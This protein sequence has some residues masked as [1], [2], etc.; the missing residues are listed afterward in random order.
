MIFC[1]C[2]CGQTRLKYDLQG[3]ERLYIKYH[4]NNCRQYSKEKKRKLRYDKGITYEQKFGKEKAE[5][6][7]ERIKI[8][9]KNNSS[10]KHFKKG[11][12]GYWLGKKRSSDT[13]V[14]IKEARKKQ[15]IKPFSEEHKRKI[16]DAQIGE[17]NHM[18]DKIPSEATRLKL[19]KANVGRRLS[20]ITPA[21]RIKL[22]EYR[23]KQVFPI[24]DTK[25]E[26]KIQ[27]FLNELGIEFFAHQHI[28]EI[29]YGYQCDI[30][31]PKQDRILQKTII[32]CDG[33][34]WHG[35]PELKDFRLFSKKIKIQ[36]CLDFEKT[37]QLEEQGFRVIRLWEHEIKPME[38]NQFK[39]K[40]I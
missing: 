7:K 3:R 32:E 20:I 5:E 4:I 17:K 30:F 31:I 34:Y 15:I 23:I 24:Q 13:I 9:I 16:G 11:N 2:G 33:D 37:A 1:V 12:P 29:R 28:S 14:K 10:P 8:A 6:I 27:N 40:L 19:H 36:R 22:R 39:E 25:I 35:N 18:W 38:I 26:V 21:G